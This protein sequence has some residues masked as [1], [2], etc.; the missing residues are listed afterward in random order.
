MIVVFGRE[1]ALWCPHFIFFIIFNA[2]D[3][4]FFFILRPWFIV[5]SSLVASLWRKPGLG[6]PSGR[7]SG[8]DQVVEGVGIKSWSRTGLER[9]LIGSGTLWRGKAGLGVQGLPSDGSCIDF[10]AQTAGFSIFNNIQIIEY[11]LY[12]NISS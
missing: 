7:V 8:E 5:F 4:L 9:R 6:V 3:P 10:E 2:W 11:S 12:W 1:W